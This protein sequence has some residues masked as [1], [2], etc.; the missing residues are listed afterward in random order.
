[1]VKVKN[2]KL[3]ANIHLIEID[4]DDLPYDIIEGKLR[5]PLEGGTYYCGT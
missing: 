3:V 2:L 5:G 1:M 4:L